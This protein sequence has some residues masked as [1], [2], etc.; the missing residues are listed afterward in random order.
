MSQKLIEKIALP[1]GL[2]LEIWDYSRSIAKDTDKV[3]LYICAPIPLEPS[4]FSENSQYEKTRKCLGDSLLFEYRNERSFVV[5]A[6]RDQIFRQFVDIFKQDTLPY[7][8]KPDFPRRF[9]LSKYRE[10]EKNP[11]QYREMP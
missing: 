7:L 8:S 1:N 3:T 5:Q 10:I 4:F 9:A 6:E 11:Y 2:H